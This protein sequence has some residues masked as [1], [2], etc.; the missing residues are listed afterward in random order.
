MRYTLSAALF[1]LLT[2]AALLA[3]TPAAP[4]S[5]SASQVLSAN[6]FGPVVKWFSVEYERKISPAATL[7]GSATH[8]GEMDLNE[9]LVMVR[10]YPQQKALD[11]FY[12]GARAG[13][14]GFKSY[15]YDF[16]S[17]GERDVVMPGVGVELGYNWLLGPKQNVSVG[18]G[19]ALTRIGGDGHSYSVPSV[20]PGFRLTV[21]FAF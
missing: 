12:L 15:T 10:W 19:F 13:A 17:Y 5:D 6:P 21:G 14:F 11:G 2:P 7:G 20:L 1:L 9:A 3:Q 4:S 8:Y 16:R 18:T